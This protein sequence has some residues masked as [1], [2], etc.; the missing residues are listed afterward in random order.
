M[1]D[2]EKIYSDEYADIVA[3]AG[4][5]PESLLFSEDALVRYFGSRF[6]AVYVK[7][8]LLAQ[9]GISVKCFEPFVLGL[10]ESWLTDTGITQVLN[11][12]TLQA[13]GTGVLIG[14]IDTGINYAD[15]ALIYPDGTSK[16]AACW[17]QENRSGTPPEGQL[18]GTEILRG[19]INAALESG[20]LLPVAENSGHGTRL[21]R[22]ALGAAPGAEL[23]VVK[24]KRAKKYIMEENLFEDADAFESGD[25]MAGL[26]YIVNKRAEIGRPVSVVIG[27]GTTQGAHNGLSILE[28]YIS[29]L[30]LYA[31]VCITV[32]AG[33]EGLTQH[34]CFT[35]ADEVS[36]TIELSVENSEGFTMWL[37]NDYL[38][39][40]S[41]GVISPIGETVQPVQPVNLSSNNFSLPLGSGNIGIQYRLPIGEKQLSVITLQAPINGIWRINLNFGRTG[42]CGADAWLPLARLLKGNVVFTAPSTAST[43]TVPSTAPLV[44]AVGGYN[45]KTGGIYENTGRGPNTRSTVR[46]DIVAPA[47]D[48]YGGTGTS[49]AAAITAGAAALLLQWG[50]VQGNNPSVMTDIIKTYLIAGANRP[51]SN[52]ETGAEGFPNN[53]WGHG[54]LDLYNTFRQI[55]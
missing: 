16:I 21:A 36:R 19:D 27:L 5:L 8:S 29:E 30:S 42:L 33:N 47:V 44:I 20:E 24:L 2:E 3:I 52:I 37:W 43:V 46:P 26:E 7:R 14:I 31:G 45:D 1:T 12:G 53:I 48:I 17:D 23:I 4:D 9:F 34:H 35:R 50:I 41:V 54:K 11:S 15:E 40:L 18:Y 49:S 39:R 55:F 6:S 32:A 38:C 25:V 51:V 28:Q 22:T 13:D 10:S